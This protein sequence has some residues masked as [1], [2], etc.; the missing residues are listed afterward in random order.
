MALGARGDGGVAVLTSVQG[1]TAL[2]AKGLDEQGLGG[3]DARIGGQRPRRF[4]GLETC[5]DDISRTHVVVA[6]EGRKSRAP[7]AGRHPVC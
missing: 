4:D 6:T 3:D 7:F 1:D 5:V 2:A